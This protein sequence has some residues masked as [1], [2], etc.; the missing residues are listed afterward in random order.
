MNLIDRTVRDLEGRYLGRTIIMVNPQVFVQGRAVLNH[1][2]GTKG[3]SVE[4]M[5]PTYMEVGG[6]YFRGYYTQP[7]PGEGIECVEFNSSELVP[8]FR[9]RFHGGDRG[10]A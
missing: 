8:G 5:G 9:R 1:V 6:E 7:S 2:G 10:Q 4:F 3:A